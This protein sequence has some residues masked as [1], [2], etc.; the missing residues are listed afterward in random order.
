[1]LFLFCFS[2]TQFVPGFIV[3]NDGDTIKGYVKH[4]SFKNLQSTIQ[5]KPHIFDTASEVLTVNEINAFGLNEGEMFQKISYSNQNDQSWNVHFG[6]LMLK[7]YYQLFS[8][9]KADKLYFVVQTP[10]DST[11]LTQDVDYTSTG[12]IKEESNY[13]NLILFFTRNCSRL[14]RK[15][16]N[17]SH[18]KT[19]ILSY[20]HSLNECLAFFNYPFY[21]ITAKHGF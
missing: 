4:E 11:Y 3:R 9:M 21:L 10:E 1:M 20:M 12:A 16:E 5:F 6:Q 18:N 8:F 19:D 2:Q 13:K 7:G 17:L 15:I 14:K